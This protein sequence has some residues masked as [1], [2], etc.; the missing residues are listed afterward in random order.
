[1]K[2]LLVALAVVIAI[3]GFFLAMFANPIGWVI[4]LAGMIA[5]IV[6]L[7]KHDFGGR[8]ALVRRAHT[9]GAEDRM[10][11]SSDDPMLR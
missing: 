3:A 8:R 11:G 2:A 10:R 6:A 7:L 1:M 9:H 5:L 4:V